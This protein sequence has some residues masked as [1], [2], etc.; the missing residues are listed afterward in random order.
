MAGLDRALMTVA[1]GLA[2]ARAASRIKAEMLNRRL[3]EMRYDA[4][5]GGRRAG[6]FRDSRADA[7]AAAARRGV[8]GARAHDLSR[9]NPWAR[10]AQDV[11]VNNV[12]GD[13]I[14][15]KLTGGSD[16]LRAEGRDWIERHL[17]TTAIDFEGRQNL[18]GLQQL[19]TRAMVEGGEAL[20]VP[21]FDSR[22]RSEI[23]LKLRVLESEYLDDTVYGPS[24]EVP[25]NTV[26]DGIEYDPDG[27]RVAY[28]IHDQHP[29]TENPRAGG[30]RLTSRRY[31]AGSVIHLYRQDRPG[32]M[33]GVTWF[34][35]V[36]MAMQ[37]LADYQ[38]AQIMRQKVAACF[39][40]FWR[41]DDT[42]PGAGPGETL[43]PGLIQKIGQND[44]VVLANPP[45]A[46]GFDEFMRS[47]LRSI[48]SG[49]GVT[50]EALSGD[51]GQVNFSSAR[52]GRAEM[53]RAV[54]SWQREILVPLMMDRIG[55]WF[56]LAWGFADP[57]RAAEIAALGVKWTPPH[58][59]LVDPA[60]EIPALTD[61]VRAGFASRQ[62]VVR[63]LGQDPDRLLEEQ[64]ED[65]ASADAA[66]LVFDTDPRVTSGS[67]VTQ[68]RPEG[69]RPLIEETDDE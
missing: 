65:R 13:G 19:A 3:N 21:I 54:S 55:D 29:G 15:P 5:T 46:A 49:L 47:V 1:P 17:G 44:E 51:L 62:G 40:A 14:L 43:S 67:G 50:Y 26:F 56:R 4:A 68:A 9:N 8:M 64:I 33:R 39:T 10:R 41:S 22:R 31:P 52:M 45:E 18:Y 2:A 23:P 6:T 58:R 42:N 60:R 57:V 63:E 69:S 35:P 32:Q 28:W 16:D 66:G 20:I 11:I 38:D 48:A 34:A 25:G 7:D 36:M 12:V 61:K 27:R 37:D 59:F 30:M 53:D 24:R